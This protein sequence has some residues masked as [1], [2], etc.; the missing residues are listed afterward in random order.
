MEKS[1]DLALPDPI[2]HHAPLPEPERGEMSEIEEWRPIPGVE[3]YEASSLGRMRVL[4]RRLPVEYP[5]KRAFTRFFPAK[6]L[7]RWPM[8]NGYWVCSVEGRNTLV[9]RMVCIAFHGAPPSPKHEAEHLDGVR[10]NNVPTNLQWATHKENE[11]RKQEHGTS[12]LG[13]RNAGAL[14][15]AADI[16]PIFEAYLMADAPAV[17]RQFGV[18]RGC[19]YSVVKRKTWAHVHVPDELVIAARRRARRNQR[20]GAHRMKPPR[21]LGEQNPRSRLTERQVILAKEHAK[22]GGNL[23]AFAEN[24]GVSYPTL[25]HAVSGRTWKYLG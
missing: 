8:P 24:L 4:E 10:A 18:D 23:K 11:A 17:A 9:S 14:L 13:E 22:A 2:A 7:S 25:W 5:G 6:E 12:P 1:S 16:V 19:I 20:E 15:K 3:Y 21:Y